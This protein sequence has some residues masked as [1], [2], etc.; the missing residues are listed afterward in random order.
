MIVNADVING[1]SF[2]ILPED[3]KFL[4]FGFKS[5]LEPISTGLGFKSVN[6]VPEILVLG[7]PFEVSGLPVTPIKTYYPETKFKALSDHQ[8]TVSAEFGSVVPIAKAA[9]P[10]S[11]QR[12]GADGY[13]FFCNHI[14]QLFQ[15]LTEGQ[16]SG[17]CG[18]FDWMRKQFRGQ[19]YFGGINES[20]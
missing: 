12:I 18:E 6:Q 9:I 13:G 5:L 17:V 10:A 4:P 3:L 15:K 2:Q 8:M 19:L 7:L 14:P 11:Y 1:Y 20:L 16:I